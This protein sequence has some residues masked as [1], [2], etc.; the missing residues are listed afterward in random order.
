M[1]IR[2]KKSCKEGSEDDIVVLLIFTGNFSHP[3]VAMWE[4]V[5][6]CFLENLINVPQYLLCTSG[7]PPF[8]LF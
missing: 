1:G 6:S 7:Y 8:Q 5:Q 3:E 2:V 4:E